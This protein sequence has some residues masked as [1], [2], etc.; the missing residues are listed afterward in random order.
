M[1]TTNTG[2]RHILSLQVK[3]DNTADGCQWIG[4]LRSLETH[5]INC[6]FALLPCPNQCK[7]G[8]KIH[9]LMRKDIENHKNEVCPRQQFACPHCKESGEYQERTTKH[10]K[11]CP[12]MKTPCPNDGCDEEIQRCE[13]ANHSQECL[14][15]SVACKYIKLGCNEMIPR[16]DLEK[17]QN[18]NQQHLQLAIDTV[19]QQQITINKL[20]EKIVQ[21]CCTPV[22]F[23]VADFGQLKRSS[24]KYYCPA[25]YTSS[26]GYKMCICIH[27]NDRKGTHVSF[28]AHLMCGENDDH[29]PWP[30]TGTVTIELLN[31]LK[32]DNHYCRKIRYTSDSDSR[33]SHRVLNEERSTGYGHV[34]FISHS[35]LGYDA[36][37]HCQYLKDDCLYF[38]VSVDT[39]EG[40]SKPW[41][42]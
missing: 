21:M 17:H 19:N 33:V 23:R 12:K 35:S 22:K 41:L 8:D 1:C 29:L 16:R 30:F 26:H 20:E 25:F 27:A 5:L 39:A 4:E 14:F 13:M 10:L 6:D 42:F 36:V 11:E 31:Q 32:D 9:K 24:K 34:S 18:D 37:N 28:F 2:E 38:I 40:T 3:C 7:D 15:E